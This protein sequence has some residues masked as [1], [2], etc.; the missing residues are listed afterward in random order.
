MPY[1]LFIL[2]YLRL[3]VLAQ[4]VLMGRRIPMNIWMSFSL[5]FVRKGRRLSQNIGISNMSRLK[6]LLHF[7]LLN[8]DKT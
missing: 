2:L 3:M 6:G 8:R 4:F 7:L 5:R 1:V